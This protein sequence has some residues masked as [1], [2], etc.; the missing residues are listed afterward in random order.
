MA[1]DSF[2]LELTTMAHGG[3]AMGRHR[4]QVVFVPWA[5]PGERIEARLTGR[6][7]RVAFAEGLRLLEASADRVWPQCPHFG[8]GRCGQCHWQH[9][10]YEAQLLLKQDVLADQ[11]ARVGGFRDV[12]VLPTIPAP[13]T[14]GYSWQLALRVNRAGQIGLASNVAGQV[15]WPGACHVAHPDLLELLQALDLDVSNLRELQLLRGQGGE[16]ML[17]LTMRDERAPEL[18]SDLPASVNMLLRGGEPVNL[19]GAAHL[20]REVAGRRFRV[21]AGSSFRAHD[22]LLPRL[23][24]LVQEWLAPAP[25]A[26]VLD[27]YAGVGF[28]S[29]FLAETAGLVTLV[30]RFP[31]AVTDAESNLAS[32]DNIDLIEGPVEQVLPALEGPADAAVLDPPREGLSAAAIDGLARTKA[33]RLVYV[34]GDAATLARD[35]RRLRARGWQLRQAQPVDL[36]PLTWR[37]NAAALLERSRA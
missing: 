2:E 28:F 37:I 27:L 10:D 14:R 1:E 7:G 12:E 32:L 17:L 3:R 16:L 33:G 13:D 19:I 29:A 5:I 18:H 30:E 31:P 26:R 8:P 25:G 22:A 11:L 15:E 9:I 35:A 36:E 23:A 21:T 20:V 34:S 6:S 24:M 4:G